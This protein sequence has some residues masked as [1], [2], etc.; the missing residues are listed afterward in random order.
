MGTTFA[1]AV[2]PAVEPVS[3]VKRI[4]PFVLM[5]NIFPSLVPKTAAAPKLLPFCIN[6]LADAIE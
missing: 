1:D 6:A 3:N 2:I 5:D 4:E